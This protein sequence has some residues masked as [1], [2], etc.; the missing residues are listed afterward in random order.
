[1]K[2]ADVIISYPYIKYTVKVTHFT[3]RKSTAIEW[4]I[5]EAISRASTLEEYRDISAAA[6]FEHLFMISDADELIRPCI[7]SL[8][9]M[10]AINASGV[11][12]STELSELPM[13]SMRMTPKGEEMQRSGLL[14]GMPDD[15]MISVVYETMSQTIAESTNI[16]LTD[17]PGGITASDI[18]EAGDI[19]FPAALIREMINSKRG[20]RSHYSWLMPTTRI[21]SVDNAGAVLCWRNVSKRFIM[22]GGGKCTLEGSDDI[23]LDQRVLAG[24]KLEVSFD[25]DKIPQV[26]FDDPD[27]ELEEIFDAS[28]MKD[29]VTAAVGRSDVSVMDN[30]FF[31]ELVYKTDGKNKTFRV[32]IADNADK[33]GIELRKNT[34][35]VF[36]PEKLLDVG[37][38]Y[39]DRNGSIREGC[40]T[41]DAHGMQ[42]RVVF[43]YSESAQ[44]CDIDD[45][46]MKTAL[47]YAED[48]P[49]VLFVLY[50]T[51][52]S[53]LFYDTVTKLVSGIVDISERTQALDNINRFGQLLYNKKVLSVQFMTDVL[54][55]GD[56]IKERCGSIDDMIVAMNEYRAVASDDIYKA[57][58]SR[59]LSDVTAVHSSADIWKLL[60]AVQSVKSAYIN[61]IAQSGLYRKLYSE[62]IIS[63]LLNDFKNDEIAVWDKMPVEHGILRLRDIFADICELMPEMANDLDMSSEGIREA[64]IRK[65]DGIRQICEEIRKWKEAL[66]Y[67]EK[68]AGAV[69]SFVSSGSSFSHVLT[70]MER[71][72]GVTANL[73]GDASLKY[74]NVY[75][76][77]TSALLNEP[78]LISNLENGSALL[79]VPQMVLNE[80]DGLKESE[81]DEE[82]YKARSAIRAIANHRAFDWLNVKESGR[83]ELIPPDLGDP[84]QPDNMILS[85]AAGYLHKAP[86]LLSDDINL[87]NKAKAIGVDSMG[88]AAFRESMIRVNHKNKPTDRKKK[89]RN[90]GGKV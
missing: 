84:M 18:G 43:A 31:S 38:A 73:F 71:I 47:K 22:S 7:L 46:C 48:D 36:V 20:E 27:K 63:D 76:V 85:V 25:A 70:A 62:Q 77:D 75:I 2:I 83:P 56:E 23:N 12:N 80:L 89:I 79:V 59:A 51:G 40:F 35:T 42:R 55:D 24:M 34:L 64:L 3:A 28:L 26:E 33:F 14:P 65:R 61:W 5:L 21:D 86:V 72:S 60:D 88:S 39:S 29:K 68:M 45:V 57:F 67:F 15:S 30:A 74:S 13:G 82:A 52:N 6:L 4:L 49:R 53:G 78:E 16:R 10:G 37:A 44:A 54:I 9:D 1:M 58:L 32:V 87:C 66:E 19:T 8:Q 11:D 69:D 17:V 81:N 41:L 50:E 90:N